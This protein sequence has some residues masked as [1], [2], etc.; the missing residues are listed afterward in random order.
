MYTLYTEV[1]IALNVNN[2]WSIQQH[3][4]RC[5]AVS[6][7]FVG[8]QIITE[9]EYLNVINTGFDVL[10]GKLPFDVCQD[11]MRLKLELYNASSRTCNLSCRPPASI[12][13]PIYTKYKCIYRIIVMS[14]T[15]KSH[16]IF[17]FI[18]EQQHGTDSSHIDS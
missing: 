18:L 7:I 9:M 17:R 14:I 2:L 10:I 11:R 8:T 13:F 5:Y 3:I 16:K 15:T 1:F 4:S 12:N 6:I